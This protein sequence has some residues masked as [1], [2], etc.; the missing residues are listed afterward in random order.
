VN[1]L[2]PHWVV[3]A[4]YV[5]LAVFVGLCA[6]LVPGVQALQ[7]DD[8]VL[9]F[10]PPEHEDVVAFREVADRFG[11]LS[12]ALVGLRADGE[13]LLVPERTE[14]IRELGKSIAAADG[15]RLV[16]GYPDLPDPKVVGETLVVEPLVP[17]GLSAEE[18]RARVVI[19]PNAVG[20]MISEDGTSAALLVYLIDTGDANAR[21]R[22]LAA[23]RELVEAEWEGEAWFGGGPFIE[24]IAAQSSRKD[25]EKLSPVVIIV[26]VVTSAL[27][28]GSATGAALNL[29]LTGLGIGLVVG[30]HGVF[31]EPFTIVSSTTPVLMV[32]LGGAF[33]MHMISGYQRQEGDPSTRASNALRELWVAVVLSGLTTAVAFFALLVMPQ[34]PMQRFGMVAGMGVLMLLALALLVLPAMLSLLPARLLPTRPVRPLP[35]RWIPPL[36]LMIGLAIVGIVLGARLTA[37]P[38]TRNVF[39]DDSEP[40]LADAFFNEHFGGSQFVQIAVEADLSEPTVLREIRGIVSQ[41]EQLPHVADVRS[42]LDPVALVTEGFGGRAGVPQTTGQAH[43]VIVNLAD[44]A[45]MKQLMTTDGQG[46]IIHVKLAPAPSEEQLATTNRIREIVGR[47]PTLIRV[48]KAGSPDVDAARRELV[49]GRVVELTG[50]EIDATEFDTLVTAG[51]ADD[52]AL[53]AEIERLRERAFATDEL[54]EEPLAE[55][56]YETLAP[57]QLV[58]TRG[59]A[60]E[61]LLRA[62]LPTLVSKDPEGIPIVVEQLGMW[63]DEARERRRIEVMCDRLELP[64]GEPAKPAV[65]KEAPKQEDDPLGLGLEDEEEAQ[66]PVKPSGPC[67]EL[68]TIVSELGDAEWSAPE[69]ANVDVLREVP[70]AIRITGQPIIGQAFAQSVTDS[71]RWSTLVSIVALA[72]VLLVSRHLVA[73]VPALW[74][75]AVTLGLIVLLGHPISIGTSMVTCIA[76]GAGV[77]FAIH[78]GVRARR[79]GG[80]RAAVDELGVVILITGL[81][82]AVAFLVMLA[83]SMPPLRQFGV[84]LAIGLLG[85][86]AGAVWLAPRLLKD[87]S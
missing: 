29:V 36:W 22:N 40:A 8:D 25:L 61:K 82:L 84:G 18:I 11:M 21:A 71:M 56:E 28:L 39:D 68:L 77:D 32:A 66:A 79:G 1:G 44:E 65:E 37:D 83:S 62:Q 26:L 14:Q 48:A 30:A 86:A 13:D 9:A 19:N 3:R 38:D 67:G 74:T 5:I 49:R 6:W 76:L 57:A 59:A 17:K 12:V 35:M 60:L 78:L 31:G 50:K 72:L 4:R 75:L 10:L 43:T 87:R 70:I 54:I 63:I 51:A 45:A 85:A 34:V 53:L 7:H 73:L 24:D 27:L 33:G 69:D 55:E 58:T 52:P 47:A 23:I 64:Q 15:V 16:L 2:G 41:V 20:S 42:L 81:Q 80:G 46:A